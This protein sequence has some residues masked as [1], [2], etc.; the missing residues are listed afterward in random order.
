MHV[1]VII[2]VTF[3]CKQLINIY[4]GVVCVVTDCQ[5]RNIIEFKRILYNTIKYICVKLR[6]N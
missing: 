4:E 5:D 3:A 6:D 2:M 1:D